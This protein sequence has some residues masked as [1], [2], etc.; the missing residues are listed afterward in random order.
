[1]KIHWIRVVIAGIWAEA[2]LL[3]IY[4]PVLKHTGSVFSIIV[5]ALAWFG[6]MFLG[7][8]WVTRRVDSSFILHGALVAIVATVAFAAVRPIV[9]PGPFQWIPELR[10]IAFKMLVCAAGAYV[11]GRRRKKLLS[12][13]AGQS[14][15]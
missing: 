10:A 4:L 7:G 15:S 9:L 1:M 3:A 12:A 2:L 5:A 11:G 6:S 8:L 14:P 13:Q